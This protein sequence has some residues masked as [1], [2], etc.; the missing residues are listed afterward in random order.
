M[1]VR[2]HPE[3]YFDGKFWDQPYVGLDYGSPSVNAEARIGVLERYDN[4]IADAVWLASQT[5]RDLDRSD[6]DALIR[7][8]LSLRLI[9]PDGAF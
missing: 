4:Y 2:D 5:P 7:S 6:R 3:L 1:F 9:R 8:T